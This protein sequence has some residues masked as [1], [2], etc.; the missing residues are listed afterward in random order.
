MNVSIRKVQREITVMVLEGDLDLYS[1]PKVKKEIVR[2]FSEGETRFVVD[3]DAVPYLDSS[4]IGILLYI[5][6]SCQ[7]R[8]LHVFF[9]HLKGPVAKVISLTKLD[10]FLPIVASV[11]SAIRRLN[12]AEQAPT[13]DDAIKQIRVDSNDALFDTTGMYYKTFFIDM[14]HVRRL[15]NLI[16]QKAPRHVQ[17]INMLEQQVSEILK[18]GVRH[19]NKNEKNK[20]LH[21]W[22]SFNDQEA[23]LIVQDEGSGFQEIEQWNEFYQKK[24][25]CY[26]NKDFDEMMNYLA[27]RTERSTDADGGNAMFAAIEYWNGGLVFN[28]ERNAVAV[29]RVFHEG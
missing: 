5:Y 7:K 21:I 26:R 2:L 10:G 11:E 6:T 20:A 17:E 13:A 27:F 4:G 16:A 28:N 3:L 9:T 22:F 15:S 14:S 18:N 29:R 24:I 1:T 8:G 19:G 23:R 12:A 25:E